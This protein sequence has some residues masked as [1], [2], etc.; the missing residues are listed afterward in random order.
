[1]F[2]GCEI[3]PL[4]LRNEHRLRVFQNRVLRIFGTKR[5]EMVG[6]RR[7]LHNEELH[8]LYSSTN[9]IKIIKSRRMRWTGHVALRRGMHTERWWESQKR[10]KVVGG[11]IILKLIYESSGSIKCW[12]MLK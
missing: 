8:N 1:V 9:L 12:E 2:Y 3:L 10:K 4:I 6:G 11:G 5:D 7:R